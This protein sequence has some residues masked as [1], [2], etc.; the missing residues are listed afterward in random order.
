VELE[1]MAVTDLAEYDRLKQ[2]L[3]SYKKPT[4]FSKDY[5]CM[6]E[7]THY[8]SSSS[9][10]VHLKN[11]KIALDQ[12]NSLLSQSHSTFNSQC[13]NVAKGSA[14]LVATDTNR[15]MC[16]ATIMAFV[17]TDNIQVFLNDYGTFVEVKLS[18]LDVISNKTLLD[19]P[20]V[21]IHCQL[22]NPNSAI[23]EEVCLA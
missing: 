5:K 23:S 11:D 3:V 7:L 2:T 20:S 17:S 18:D 13:F 10:Y 9:F 1:L 21:A 19:I 14:C 15:K 16:R 8:E 6:F 22:H 12:V 4:L